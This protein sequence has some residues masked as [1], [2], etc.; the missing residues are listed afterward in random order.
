[1][2]L[3]GCPYRY[4]VVIWLEIQP[5]IMIA[6]THA[7]CCYAYSATI[8]CG[9]SLNKAPASKMKQHFFFLKLNWRAVQLY[10]LIEM[11]QFSKNYFDTIIQS[12]K[13]LN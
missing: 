11:L 3:E 7:I 9:N 12:R 6:K 10:K 5:C 1:M 2:L 13:A 8:Y 4:T